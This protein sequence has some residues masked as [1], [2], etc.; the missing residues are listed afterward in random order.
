MNAKI[1][2]NVDKSIWAYI[3]VTHF[4]SFGLIMDGCGFILQGKA[5]NS[6]VNK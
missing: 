5:Q 4:T 1:S 3:W 2:N 6:R